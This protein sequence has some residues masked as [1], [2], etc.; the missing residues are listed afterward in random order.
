MREIW[1]LSRRFEKAMF[2]EE[3]LLA[4]QRLAEI[5]HADQARY[6]GETYFVGH[7]SE[8]AKVV[9][10]LRYPD[11]VIAAAYLHDIL[12]DTD[13]EPEELDQFGEEVKAIVVACTR[14][15]GMSR[16]QSNPI[17][18]RAL[19]ECPYAEH[20][21]VVK[22][23]DRLVNVS[24]AWRFHSHLLFMYRDEHKSF[25]EGLG[26]SDPKW[27]GTPVQ[28]LAGMLRAELGF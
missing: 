17:T 18:Y 19:R 14:P 5:R 12:E 2:S 23:A 11:Q 24:T 26:L 6:A 15:R 21:I 20:A 28:R 16:R 27:E 9:A 25:V 22:L 1:P 10:K 7:L 3:Q 13:T 4:A 8:V